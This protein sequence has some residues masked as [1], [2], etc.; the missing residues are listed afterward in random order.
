M[1]TQKEVFDIINGLYHIVDDKK[2][3]WFYAK[4]LCSYLEYNEVTKKVVK[5]H[6][7]DESFKMAYSKISVFAGGKNPPAKIRHN[8]NFINEE[9]LYILIEK[10]TKPKAEKFKKWARK[11]LAKIRLGDIKVD[12]SDY[13]APIIKSDKDTPIFFDKSQCHDEESIFFDD[14]N[15]E[16]K[17]FNKLSQQ[18]EYKNF[19]DKNVLYMFITS[20]KNVV[21]KKILVK[22]GYS[23]QILKRAD[24]HRARFG[25]HFKLVALKEVNDIDDE[26]AFHAHLRL[27][28]PE[29]IYYFQI[30]NNAGK[31]IGA[32]E[33]YIFD[34]KI[35]NEFNNYNIDIKKAQHIITDKDIE[36]KKLELENN[37]VLLDNNKVLLELEKY[38]YK[39]AKA[40][41]ELEKLKK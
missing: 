14:E 19:I 8:E 2:N 24:E 28:Y 30:R 33:F 21:N 6:I 34:E 37:K 27:K 26:V 25:A 12:G 20:I 17:E 7:K 29:L 22:I 38:K 40:L 31:K 11:I 10:S 16:I 23:K 18:L 15:E 32:D 39:H 41:L 5:D 36:F 35:M 1:T 9:A 4:Q 3:V 13:I